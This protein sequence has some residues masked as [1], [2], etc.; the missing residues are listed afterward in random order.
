M[1]DPLDYPETII[2]IE[3]IQGDILWFAGLDDRNWKSETYADMAL[4]RCRAKGKAAEKK[5][6]VRAWL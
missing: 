6:Q 2:P 5:L 4:E 1:D 3:D